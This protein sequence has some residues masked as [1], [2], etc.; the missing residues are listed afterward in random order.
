MRP[1]VI[2]LDVDGVLANFIEANLATLRELGVERQHD[3]VRAWSIEESLGL[4]SAQRAQ[5]KA[6]WSEAGFCASIPAYEGAAAGV[7]LLRSIGEVYAITAPMWSAP[8]WQH[9]RTEWLMRHFD[10]TR[11]QV[12]STAAKHLVRGDILVEDKPETLA[13]WAAAWPGALPVLWDRPYNAEADHPV[14]TRS[15]GLLQAVAAE[16]ARGLDVATAGGSG[17][18]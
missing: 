12:V 18:P 8:T 3:D 11:D 13:R 16:V 5:M 1:L 14:R 17:Q 15:W 6:R 9:E 4:S 10:F 7:E 2:L